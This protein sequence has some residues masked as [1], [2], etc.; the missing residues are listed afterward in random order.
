VPSRPRR[1]V[2]R[3]SGTAREGSRLRA[4]AAMQRDLALV[5][6]HPDAVMRLAVES[7]LSLTAAGGAAIDIIEGETVVCRAAGRQLLPRRGMRH[8]AADALATLCLQRGVVLR[9]DDLDADPHYDR[10]RGTFH[11]ARSLLMAPLAAESANQGVLLVTA[12]RR[13]GFDHLDADA[14]HIAAGLVGSAL[15]HAASVTTHRALTTENAMVMAALAEREQRFRALSDYTSDLVTIFDEDGFVRYAS[16]SHERK[17]GYAPDQL[18]GTFGWDLIHPDDRDR[19]MEAFKPIDDAPGAV[20]TG[21]G[22]IRHAG[23]HWRL[24]ELVGSNHLDNPAVRGYIYN[25]HDVTERAEAEATLRAREEEFRTVVTNAPGI[26]FALDRNGVYTLSEGTGLDRLGRNPGQIVGRHIEEVWPESP[27]AQD[28]IWRALAGEANRVILERR[29]VIFDS[30]LVPLRD[31]GGAVVGVIG[32]GTDITE[33]TRSAEILSASEE[34]FR[35]L[36]ETAPI[37]I[38]IFDATARFE[39]VNPAFCEMIGYTA[40]ELVGQHLTFVFA[41]ERRQ[42]AARVFAERYARAE[43]SSGEIEVLTRSGSILTILENGVTIVGADGKHKRA[44]FTVD[45]TDRARSQRESERARGAA[46]E[47]AR[48]RSDFVASVSHELRT[49]LTAIVGYAELLQA[50]WSGIDDTRRLAQISKIVLSANRQQRL[51]DDLLLLSQAEDETRDQDGEAAPLGTLVERAAEE[52]RG[53]YRGQ[54][55]Q[56]DGPMSLPVFVNPD[57]AVQILVNLLDNAAKYSTEGSPID[58]TWAPS[59]TMA[60]IAVRDRGPGIPAR[61][62]AQLFARFGRVSGSRIRAGRVGTGLGLYL[63]RRL[64]EAMRGT[65]DLEST[66]PEGSVFRLM[67][68][69]AT[70]PLPEDATS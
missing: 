69:I 12:D 6:S 51:V 50:R 46:E 70:T 48:L 58:I 56:L 29:G 9:I 59:G 7:A 35:T 42:R 11:G 43:R 16:P 25:A 18:L 62:H 26:V 53:C 57:R 31:A 8:P 22:R 2:E 24:M 4:L 44:V 40:E 33:Q 30:R 13:D 1:G 54:S 61:G 14:L 27:P 34:R 67:L 49:P 19:L 65:L 64:A 52:V 21:E 45:I 3:R 5:G 32:L 66:G 37:G 38:C 15:R 10:Q 28:A 17:L 20:V 23:G 60:R 39:A 63:A 68:P 41:R 47:L 55:I 36:F